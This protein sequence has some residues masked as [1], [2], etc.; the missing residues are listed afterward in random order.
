MA[1]R[2]YMESQTYSATIGGIVYN[3]SAAVGGTMDYSTDKTFGG[4]VT[5]QGDLI[6]DAITGP[7]TIT[8][9]LTTTGDIDIQGLDLE[10]YGTKSLTR[11][12]GSPEGAATGPVGCLYLQT[13]GTTS[14][15]LWVKET[16]SGN[17]GW[18]AHG[19][20]AGWDGHTELADIAYDDI[21]IS[22][23]SASAFGGTAMTT[24]AWLTDLRVIQGINAGGEYS[25]YSMQLPHNYTPGS[26]L[27]FHVH[28]ANT[29]SIANGHTVVFIM[30]FT[31]APIWGLFGTTGTATATF[32]NNSTTQAQ[33][34]AV[35]PGQLDGSL[36]ILANTHLIAGGATITGTT[37]GLST[38]LYGRLER[39]GADTHGS[40]VNIISI[41]AHIQ[42]NRLGS[43]TE[44]TG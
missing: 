39:S 30:K 16:G 26:N 40:A 31:A 43:E 32:T 2:E 11:G 17:T 15:A 22:P 36:N 20:L 18:V 24:A 19:G 33:I 13:N 25:Y 3:V 29:A 23:S 12:T 34:A 8:G 27:L 1:T 14:A 7:T 10:L 37:Y 6:A 44:Y 41:D 9:K 4:D 5:V 38:V 28:F 35:A 42:K 21:I